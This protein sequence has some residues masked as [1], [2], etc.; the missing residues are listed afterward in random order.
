MSRYDDREFRL[1]D[2]WLSKQ[3]RSPAW[4]RTWYDPEKRQT[5][6]VSLGTSDVWE[7]QEKLTDWFVLNHRQQQEAPQEADLAAVLVRYWEDHAKDVRS[8]ATIKTHLGHWTHY[9]AESTVGAATTYEAIEG[10]KRHLRVRG[11]SPSGINHVLASGRAA[12]HLAWKRGELTHVP[13]VEKEKIGQQ[14]PMGRPLSIS[15]CRLLL[16]QSDRPETQHLHR[17]VL[18][19]LGTAARPGALLDLTLGQMDIDRRLIHLNPPGRSQNKKYRPTVKM[20]E[21]ILQMLSDDT[22]RSENAPVI[23]FRG[24]PVKNVKTAWR[25]LRERCDLDISVTTYSFRH[26]IARHLRAEGVPAWEVAAQLGHKTAGRHR[27]I[28]TLLT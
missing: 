28:R 26:T 3:A 18:L 19:G 24:A 27:P 16:E 14:E 7:A 11:L 2:Y 23:Q 10:F 22:E 9:F 12:M 6:R 20:P 17:L 25:K 5:K 13:P 4:C 1:G 21:R 15:E 8:A